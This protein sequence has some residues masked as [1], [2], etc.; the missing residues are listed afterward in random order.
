LAADWELC[1]VRSHDELPAAKLLMSMPLHRILSNADTDSMMQMMSLHTFDRTYK[2]EL[3]ADL[4]PLLSREAL[5]RIAWATFYADSMVDG[6][7]FG[8][9]VVDETALG[10]L[11][12]PCD[13]SS[14]AINQEC[15]TEPLFPRCSE[16]RDMIPARLGISAYLL[17][18]AAARRRALH[19][20]F[21]ATHRERTVEDLTP[22]LAQIES[23][24]KDITDSL[25]DH[26]HYNKHNWLLHQ[27]RL[28]TF[29]LLHVLRHNLFIIVDR[30]ALQ[31][32]RREPV[33]N[34]LIDQARHRRI[35]HAFPI[36]E[37]IAE[38]LE[39]GIAFDPHIGVQ[40]Y[41]ALESMTNPS[42]QEK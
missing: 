13:E 41:V 22:E 24:V 7:R 9:H 42:P 6:G 35:A 17:R 15:D 1:P 37:L 23:H 18:T 19:F 31:I 32:Y 38:G 20:A 30:A 27:P 3:P 16:A 39:A 28:N 10:F 25:P 33:Q 14:F 29:I 5:R 21:R 40:A 36:A 11:Q 34:D 26:L 12:L 8:F 4:S 2:S